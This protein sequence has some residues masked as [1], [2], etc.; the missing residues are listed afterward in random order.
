[1]VQVNVTA[2]TAYGLSVSRTP[3]GN[4]ANIAKF[5]LTIHPAPELASTYMFKNVVGVRLQYHQMLR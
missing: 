4:R 3:V 1:M 2:N 5:Y